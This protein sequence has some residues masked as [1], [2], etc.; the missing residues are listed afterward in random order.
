MAGVVLRGRSPSP[1]G[2]KL[3]H[4]SS[5]PK[6]GCERMVGASNAGPCTHIRIPHHPLVCVG[7]PCRQQ[8]QL[9]TEFAPGK[10][11]LAGSVVDSVVGLVILLP[12]C[13]WYAL[14]RTALPHSGF[15]SASQIR[16]GWWQW[17]RVMRLPAK[18]RRPV[19]GEER[20]LYG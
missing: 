3:S 9:E 4:E 15:Y 10:R 5:S 8:S 16:Q 7:R 18:E 14:K 19:P 13:R 6:G 20:G 2:E 11:S 17:R 1:V 12:S